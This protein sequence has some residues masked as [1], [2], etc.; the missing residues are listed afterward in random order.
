MAW[1]NPRTYRVGEL[2]GVDFS[3][4]TDL[5][6]NL[7][8]LFNPPGA[9]IRHNADQALGEDS[10][11]IL[12]LAVTSYDTDNMVITGG[13]S[14]LMC[15]TAG[16]YLL[17]GNVV[18]AADAGLATGNDKRVRMARIYNETQAI[19]LGEHAIQGATSTSI[20]IDLVPQWRGSF[21]VSDVARLQAHKKSSAALNAAVISPYAPAMYAQWIGG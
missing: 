17:G 19:T 14:G 16:D 21:A 4:T 10:I 15:R 13:A 12:N 7:N 11:T 5:T 3:M 1:T 9:R 20:Q 8:W 6:E 18:F 2:A